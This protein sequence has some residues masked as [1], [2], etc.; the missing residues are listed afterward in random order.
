MLSPSGGNVKRINVSGFLMQSL[1]HFF[2]GTRPYSTNFCGGKGQT[3]VEG[4]VNFCGVKGPNSLEG[5]PSV[6]GRTSV[7]GRVKTMW[8][9]GTNFCGG[10]NL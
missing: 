2:Q 6:E 3:T 8:S 10:S 5:Q 1:G 4:R 7:E 9:E